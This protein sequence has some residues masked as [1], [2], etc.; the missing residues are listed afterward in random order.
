MSALTKLLRVLAVV[1]VITL[2]TQALLDLTPGSAASEI[3]GQGA[4]AADVAQLNHT[5]GLDRPFIARYADWLTHSI[6]GDLGKSP[7]THEPV[8]FA[9]SRAAPVTLE[10]VL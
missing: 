5:L 1:F 3:L 7:I 6:Q 10:L 9:I 4:T 8:G 2:F